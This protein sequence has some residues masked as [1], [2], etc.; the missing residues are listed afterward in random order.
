MEKN[1]ILAIF[2]VCALILI[3]YFRE[4]SK[5]TDI[6]NNT[7]ITSGRLLE[8]R[9][10]YK[11]SFALIYEYYVDEK[12]YTSSVG[13]SPFKCDDGRKNCIGKKFTVYYS[14]KNPEN[15]RIDLGK[16]EKYKTTVELVK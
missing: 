4:Y 3:L 11:A 8:L 13:I 10:K 12:R 5:Q 7:K 16:Y 6:K 14:S 9:S 15:S 1:K 2:S